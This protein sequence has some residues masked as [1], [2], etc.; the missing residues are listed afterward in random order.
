MR[1][2]K[3]QIELLVKLV[4]DAKLIGLIYTEASLIQLY[5][6]KSLKRPLRI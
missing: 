3:E 2:I 1:S 5:R 4:P 6:Q